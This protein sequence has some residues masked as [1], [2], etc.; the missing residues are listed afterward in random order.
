MAVDISH[1]NLH[2]ISMYDIHFNHD[3]YISIFISTQC[4]ECLSPLPEPISAG[5]KMFQ[6]IE[7]IDQN[8]DIRWGRFISTQPNAAKPP[9]KSGDLGT[10]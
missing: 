9:Q 3:Y 1:D 6:G 10:Q 2:V 7:G 5:Q 4:F 8:R